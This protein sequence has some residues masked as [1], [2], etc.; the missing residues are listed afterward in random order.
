[1]TAWNDVQPSCHS[2]PDPD[3]PWRYACPECESVNVQKA[4][5]N[6][7]RCYRCRWRGD[8]LIDLR[9]KSEVHDL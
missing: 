6:T 3:E 4:T 9:T 2:K 1:M 8:V 7:Y 5:R